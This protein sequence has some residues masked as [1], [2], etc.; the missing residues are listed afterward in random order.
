MS[1]PTDT[2]RSSAP[3]LGSARAFREARPR[4]R[5]SRAA[6][7][8]TLRIHP[9]P[10][11]QD[12]RRR[13][14][15]LGGQDPAGQARHRTAQGL[16]DPA[17]RLHG[18][19][20]DDRAGRPAR[21]AGRGLRHHRDRPAARHVQRGAHRPGADH[22]SRPAGHRRHRR[23]IE[24]EEVAL[25]DWADIPWDQLAFPTVV[26]A[27]AHFH[28]SRDKTDFATYS[29]PTGDLARMWPPRKPAGV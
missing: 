5:Q 11:P 13:G 14:L 25:V 20:R 15:H 8:R 1:A 10:E 2:T 17:G 9:L 6:G 29:N 4:R 23:G 26:W 24:S 22:V 28:E 19:G 16:L 3:A 7:L 27:L 12:R 18:T 21:S